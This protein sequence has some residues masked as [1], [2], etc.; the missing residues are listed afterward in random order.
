MAFLDKM[1]CA[2]PPPKRIDPPQMN[3][4][5]ATIPGGTPSSTAGLGPVQGDIDPIATAQSTWR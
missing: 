3:A 1:I 2:L 5:A 4:L